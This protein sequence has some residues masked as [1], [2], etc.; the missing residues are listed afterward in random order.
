MCEYICLHTEQFAKVHVIKCSILYIQQNAHIHC[1]TATSIHSCNYVVWR[2]FSMLCGKDQ[3]PLQQDLL[4]LTANIHYL[5]YYMGKTTTIHQID[6]VCSDRSICTRSVILLTYFPFFYSVSV[7]CS[8]HT[9]PVWSVRAAY[10]SMGEGNLLTNIYLQC[11][12][13]H[14]DVLSMQYFIR[15]VFV[16]A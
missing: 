13:E 15:Y 2:T 11:L 10:M 4:Q 12:C 6:C 1:Q 7:R 14:C 3:A 9:I 16:Y 8:Q 5:M